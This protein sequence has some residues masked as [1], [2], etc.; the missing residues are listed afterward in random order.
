MHKKYF[1]GKD[2]EQSW[3]AF[4]GKNF[5][6]LVKFIVEDSL[7]DLG[8]ALIEGSKLERTQ[9]KNLPQ[10]LA[11]IKRKLLVD[12]GSFGYHLPDV[13]LIV[14]NPKNLKIIAIV[15]CKVTLRERIAQSAYWKLKLKEQPLTKHIKSYFITLDED[16]TLAHKLPPKKGRA[17]VET[18]LDGSYVL[19]ETPI[20][21]SDKVKGFDKFIEDIRNIM[22]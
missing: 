21:E 9:E 15:S 5:E 4:K 22:G 10:D 11:K 18:D 3:R 20:E 7:R 19:S 12:F 13:D 8:L 6:K 14:Y 1:T 16:N 2:H 17:I